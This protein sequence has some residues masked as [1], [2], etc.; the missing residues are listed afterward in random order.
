MMFVSLAFQKL[1][2]TTVLNP[3]VGSFSEKHNSPTPKTLATFLQAS[4]MGTPHGVP[5][6]LSNTI[7]ILRANF[8]LPLPLQSQP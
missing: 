5:L 3:E 4:K 6:S 8:S 2:S 1:K 7:S